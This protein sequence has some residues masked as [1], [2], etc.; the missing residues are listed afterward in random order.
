[1]YLLVWS[2]HRIFFISFKNSI[3]LPSG[4]YI[5][6]ES[7]VSFNPVHDV[8]FLTVI[9]IM[10]KIFPGPPELP[11]NS[12]RIYRILDVNLNRLREALR[13][14]EEYYRFI[15]EIEEVGITLKEMR[16]VLVT[17][18]E[19]L[20]KER[21][22][23]SRDTTTDCFAKSVRPEE[24]ARPGGLRGLLGANFKRG[25]EATRV[26]EEYSKIVAAK[27]VPDKAKQMR[28]ALYNLEK[29]VTGTTNETN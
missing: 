28:F 4:S 10:K 15:K 27:T 11:D 5:N 12:S 9:Y 6:P 29:T 22:L 1:M 26:L 16:H 17:V 8:Y 2:Y 19:E 24:R 18:E 21:L 20:G 13:V 7:A 14:I 23:D 25:Q 3:I